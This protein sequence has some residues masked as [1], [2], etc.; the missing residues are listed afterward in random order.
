MQTTMQCKL[1]CNN[2]SLGVAS[3]VGVSAE[4][5]YIGNWC[6]DHDDYD[7]WSSPDDFCFCYLDFCDDH[8]T[9]YYLWILKFQLKH[10][11]GHCLLAP[12]TTC[13]FVWKAEHI[14]K[15][16]IKI[17]YGFIILLL[18]SSTLMVDTDSYVWGGD[19]L[20]ESAHQLL[21][22]THQVW[23]RQLRWWWWWRWRWRWRWW[24]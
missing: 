4:S 14:H 3:C 7:H 18:S 5:A 10:F 12:W 8:L 15:Y 16:I 13:W 9:G 11:K 23:W 2:V 19:F 22:P 1:Q 20:V 17:I 24:W 6:D 21:G